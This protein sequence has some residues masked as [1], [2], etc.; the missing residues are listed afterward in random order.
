MRHNVQWPSCWVHGAQVS[1]EI[2]AFQHNLSERS[3]RKLSRDASPV[4][5]MVHVGFYERFHFFVGLNAGGSLRLLSFL[6]SLRPR[7]SLC[8]L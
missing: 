6:C 7:F 8:S 1:S 3:R 5:S 4:L 2:G